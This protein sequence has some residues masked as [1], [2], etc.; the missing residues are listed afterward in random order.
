MLKRLVILGCAVVSLAAADPVI[1]DVVNAASRIP[2][3]F[4]SYGIA[5]GALFA[6]TGKGLGPDQLQQAT[7]PLPTTDGLGGVNVQVTV[8]AATVDAIL[9][10][11]SATEVGAILPSKTPLGGGVVT[12]TNNGG[13]ATWPITVVDSAF[14]V[15][16]IAYY[17]STYVA[18]AYNVI[19]GADPALNYY[20]QLPNS[21]AKPGQNVRIH[22]TGLGAISSDETQSGVTDVPSAK[23]RL[24]VGNKEATVVSAGRGLFPGLP[25]G[26]PAIPVPAGVAAWDVIEF[27]VPDG[28][29]GCHVPVIVQTGTFVSDS[30]WIAV[31]ADGGPCVD[32]NTADFGDTVTFSGSAKVGTISMTRTLN[33]DTVGSQ[34]VE[35]GTEIGTAQFIQ[36]DVPD[37]LT[38]RVSVYAFPLLANNL[39]PGTCIVQLFRSVFPPVPSTNPTPTT[40]PANPPKFLDAGASI[41]FKNPNNA[42]QK[43]PQNKGGTYGGGVGSSFLIPPLPPD[44]SKVFLVP[45]TFTTDNGDGG[46]DVPAFKGTLTLPK[47]LLTFDNI[48]QLGAAID[49]TKGVTVKWSGG[50]PNSYVQIIGTSINVTGTATANVTLTGTFACA[51]R[52]SAGQFTVPPFVTLSMPATKAVSPSPPI[53]VL[54]L[55]TYGLSRIDIP[56]FDL[57]IFG[58]VLDVQRGVPYQ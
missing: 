30:P 55:W 27:T 49:R 57:G 6:V 17:A 40:P 23:I 13:K 44:N 18:L 50:D 42:I 45:G 11:V 52:I 53:G 37:P 25:D 1:T 33:R 41:N 9:V 58:I 12:L 21:I 14:G 28:V 43:I 54:S 51:E 2:S 22:G 8:G 7:F 20:V 48:D 19:D 16:T 36:F 38:T 15:F 24:F 47:P 32:E 31:S 35:I 56:T 4:P 29:L 39:N 10:Y 34:T 46:A 3:G 5:R 26:F